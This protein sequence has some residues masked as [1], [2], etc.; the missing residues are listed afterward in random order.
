MGVRVGLGLG[1]GEGWVRVGFRV[2]KGWA[3]VGVVALAHRLVVVP[4]SEL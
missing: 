2:G 1:W 3:R 4:Q